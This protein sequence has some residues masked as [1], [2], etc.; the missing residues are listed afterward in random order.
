MVKHMSCNDGNIVQTQVS[1]VTA[2]WQ[3]HLTGSTNEEE[4]DGVEEEVS[5]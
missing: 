1:T 5:I 4:G 2:L 3:A